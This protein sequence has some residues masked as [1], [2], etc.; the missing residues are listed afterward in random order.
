MFKADSPPGCFQFHPKPEPRKNFK[1]D[2]AR[3]N[4]FAMSRMTK[5]PQNARAVSAT[6]P[7]HRNLIS[8][9]LHSFMMKVI[10]TFRIVRIADRDQ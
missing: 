6:M 3:L 7:I 9:K 2:L 4:H 10:K 1:L 8:R 5:Q